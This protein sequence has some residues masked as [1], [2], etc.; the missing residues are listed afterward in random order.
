MGANSIPIRFEGLEAI[1][2]QLLFEES[3]LDGFEKQAIKYCRWLLKLSDEKRKSHHKS[4][5]RIAH[6]VRTAHGR[7]VLA[8]ISHTHRFGAVLSRSEGE[9]R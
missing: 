7:N 8:R 2:L 3:M 1:Q 5:S 6:A 4:L 9:R